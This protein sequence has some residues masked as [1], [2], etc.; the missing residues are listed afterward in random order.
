MSSTSQRPISLTDE[1]SRNHFGQAMEI[2][3]QLMPTPD[4]TH[5]GGNENNSFAGNGLRSDTLLYS[6]TAYRS[7]EGKSISLDVNV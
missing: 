5:D 7:Q 1:A 2:E 6:K 3:R 4:V